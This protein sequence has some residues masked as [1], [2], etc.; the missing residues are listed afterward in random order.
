MFIKRFVD[1]LYREG[2]M[3]EY[4]SL[5]VEN[6]NVVVLVGVMCCDLISVFWDGMLYDCD[7]N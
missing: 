6:F 1:Y 3:S 2:K 4:M 7:F 5:F